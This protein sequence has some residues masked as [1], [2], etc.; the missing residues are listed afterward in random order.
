MYE[1]LVVNLTIVLKNWQIV[2]AYITYVGIS[3]YD[4]KHTLP[5]DYKYR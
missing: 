4:Y 3:V 5:K 1:I 2:V